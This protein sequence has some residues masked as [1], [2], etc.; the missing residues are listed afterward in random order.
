M[1]ASILFSES[2][3]DL[4][5]RSCELPQSSIEQKESENEDEE[6]RIS[7][8]LT[9]LQ[10][11]LILRELAFKGMIRGTWNNRAGSLELKSRTLVVLKIIK[12]LEESAAFVSEETLFGY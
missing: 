6:Q 10:L 12:L 1:F 8:Y 9:L 7:E 5:N 2:G 11:G 4:K 3:D